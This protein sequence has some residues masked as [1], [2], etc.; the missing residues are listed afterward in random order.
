MQQARGYPAGR[1]QALCDPAAK[2]QV[3]FAQPGAF[4][5]PVIHL[6]VDVQMIVARPTD[7]GGDVVVPDAQEMGREGRIVPRAADQEI[8]SKLVHQRTQVGISFTGPHRGQPPVHRP[9]RMRRRAEGQKRAPVQ[10]PVVS[11][12]RR[13]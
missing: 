12:M 8:A 10:G 7:A 13:Q 6:G 1:H 9:G 4:G 11:L 3:A 2:R 5:R